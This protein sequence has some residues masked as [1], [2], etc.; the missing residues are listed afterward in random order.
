MIYCQCQEEPTICGGK[1][2]K[3]YPQESKL[4]DAPSPYDTPKAVTASIASEFSNLVIINPV[5]KMRMSVQEVE[6]N[7]RRKGSGK[8]QGQLSHLQTRHFKV[9]FSRFPSSLFFARQGRLSCRD[10]PTGEAFQ[11][12]L[13]AIAGEGLLDSLMPY[14]VAATKKR[15]NDDDLPKTNRGEENATVA[16]KPSILS[17]VKAFGASQRNASARNL[18]RRNSNNNNIIMKR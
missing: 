8:P 1:S 10:C 6:R 7:R 12:E 13:D 15:I 9:I 14:I 11:R 4:K 5:K 16:K 3:P 18:D 2:K 17:L